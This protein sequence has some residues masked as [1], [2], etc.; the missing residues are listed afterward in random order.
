M[1][2]NQPDATAAAPETAAAAPRVRLTVAVVTCNR[3]RFL[4]RAVRSVLAQSCR[5]FELVILENSC[6]G[7]RCVLENELSDARVRVVR[8][9]RPLDAVENWNAAVA[10]ARGDAVCIFHDDDVMQPRFVEAMMEVLSDP[11]VGMAFPL[12]RRVDCVGNDLGMYWTPSRTGR[13]SGADYV[14]MTLREHTC[15]CAPPSVVI[16]RKAYQ[17]VGLYA[18][19]VGLT[20]FDL[21]LYLRVA[22]HFDVVI[23]NELLLDYTHHP[24]QLSAGVWRVDGAVG[25][26]ADLALEMIDAAGWLLR[27]AGHDPA[28]RA[29]LADSLSRSLTQV[30][31]SLRA[32]GR[33][34]PGSG[35]ERP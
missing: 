10:E 9:E 21:N 16:T 30:H 11:S 35:A 29:E 31:E 2:A 32:W 5:Q 27:E 28:V 25:G 8:H 12:V 34:V 18:P 22:R 33:H 14:R 1:T 26:R 20:T 13:I 17:A 6:P 4:L 23:L 19:A 7:D 15:I 3:P 24:T